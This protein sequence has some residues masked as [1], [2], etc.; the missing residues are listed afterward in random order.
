MVVF[1]DAAH[2]FVLGDV[3]GNDEQLRWSSDGGKTFA[4]HPALRAC[5]VETD[6]VFEGARG[7]LVARCPAGTFSFETSDAGVTW[8]AGPRA[9]NE[10]DG[11]FELADVRHGVFTESD[12][13]HL[14]IDGGFTWHDAPYPGGPRFWNGDALYGIRDATRIGAL[15]RYDAAGHSRTL[16]TVDARASV[17]YAFSG[18]TV[19]AVV[20]TSDAS[21]VYRSRDGGDSFAVLAR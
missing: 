3:E 18:R 17:A 21:L 19:L 11:W 13:I 20:A 2:A 4:V 12:T 16:A 9:P 8:T 5:K 6:P 10:N 14:T 7:L 1:A 15:V